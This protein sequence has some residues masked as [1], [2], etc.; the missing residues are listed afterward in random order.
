MMDQGHG[1]AHIGLIRNLDAWNDWASQCPRLQT[2]H[3]LLAELESG[4]E[5]IARPVEDLSSLEK[6]VRR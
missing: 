3:E 5:R 4:N 1:P 2:R 6:R